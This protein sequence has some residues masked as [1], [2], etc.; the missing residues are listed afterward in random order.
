MLL[1]WYMGGSFFRS[2]A[3]PIHSVIGIG[4]ASGKNPQQNKAVIWPGQG[5]IWIFLHGGD[6]SQTKDDFKLA[7]L[8]ST[9]KAAEIIPSGAK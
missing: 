2:G 8:S 6:V 5:R 4:Q 1:S 3:R 7:I 9:L